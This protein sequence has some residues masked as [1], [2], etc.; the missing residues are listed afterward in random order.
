MRQYVLIVT[1][2]SVCLSVSGCGLMEISFK[3]GVITA[4]IMAAIIGL[5]IWILRFS[6]RLLSKYFPGI[7]FYLKEFRE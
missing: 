6:F 4:L 7:P 2:I 5:L 3:A 1:G